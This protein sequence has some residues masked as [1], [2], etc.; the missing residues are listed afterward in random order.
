M[1]HTAIFNYDV[2]AAVLVRAV[3]S[4]DQT[5]CKEFG[6]S[7]RTLRRY[8]RRLSEDPLLSEAVRSKKR[9]IDERWADK[10]PGALGNAI[11]FITEAARRAEAEATSYRNPALIAAI[12]GAMKLCA[13]IYY[14][15]R[16]IDARIGPEAR[17]PV[18][19]LGQGDTGADA[20][21]T[22]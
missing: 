16:W 6:I 11:S 15:G 12:A 7:D 13:E 2:A 5:A 3:Y 10:L 19:L 20:Y 9:V 17:T 22:N 1:A 21:R 8:R 14:T 18:Q 4:G